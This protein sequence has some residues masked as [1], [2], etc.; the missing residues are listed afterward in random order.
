MVAHV[1]EV[2]IAGLKDVMGNEYPV[3]LEAYLQ[4]SRE[5]LRLAEYALAENNMSALCLAIHSFK[6]SCG[7]VG[8]YELARLCQAL[9]LAVEQH[10][11]PL[12]DQLFAQIKIE[13]AA[14]RIFFQLEIQA[15][16][17]D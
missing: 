16:Q 13:L 10:N 4:D 1:D 6:G 11:R 2:I 12:R 3:L 14:V 7:N 17:A 8:A 15:S 5:R 9:E